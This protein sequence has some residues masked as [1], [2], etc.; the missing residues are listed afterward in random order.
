[1]RAGRV[2]RSVA[3]VKQDTFGVEY[4]DVQL[5]SDTLTAVGVAIGSDPEPYRLD[6]RLV[7]LRRFVTARLLVQEHGEGWNRRLD[8]R[9]DAAGTWSGAWKDRGLP[10][11]PA[12]RTGLEQLSS[13]ALDCDLGLSPL[14]NT[15]PVLRH[16]LLHGGGPIDFT[17][18]WVS[19]PD[20]GVRASRQRY[21]F[22]GAEAGRQM[23]LFEDDEG[24]TAD[25]VF[26]AE[27]LVVEYPGLARR[28]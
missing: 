18:A 26:D 9:R 3:W 13:T 17:V 21:A 10:P 6:Y 28:L 1:M 22:I 11:L 5:R 15:M 27:G 8:M 16:G 25:I 4:V 19:V 14:T 12:D 7:T 2:V 24:F 23:V 20:L